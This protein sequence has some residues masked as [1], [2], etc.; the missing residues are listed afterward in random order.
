MAFSGPQPKPEFR[1][2]ANPQPETHLIHVVVNKVHHPARSFSQCR[3]S[4]ESSLVSKVLTE[5]CVYPDT[6]LWLRI[7]SSVGGTEA[8]KRELLRVEDEIV[9]ENDVT[10]L[11][12]SGYDFTLIEIDSR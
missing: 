8:K 9:R 12:V 11:R 2:R 5:L 1:C 3:A 7:A 6:F 4:Q 10:V